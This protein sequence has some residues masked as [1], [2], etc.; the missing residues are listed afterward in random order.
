MC[1]NVEKATLKYIIRDQDENVFAFRKKTLL[2][3]E[4]LMTE[5]YGKGTVK[6]TLADQYR[7]MASI[8]KREENRH[9]EEN[10]LKAIETVGLTPAVEPIRGGTDGAAL[11]FMG[12]PCPNLGTG[13]HAFHGPYEHITVEGMEKSVGV[14]L[15]LIKIYAE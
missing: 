14:L 8:V 11:T 9:L 3:I 15:E 1:G 13:G 10:A 4:A 5:K 2:H 6:L 12:L 7:N